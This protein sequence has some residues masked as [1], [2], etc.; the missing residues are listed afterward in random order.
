MSSPGSPLATTLCGILLRNPVIAASGTFG[1]G[2]DF[3]SWWTSTRW[4]AW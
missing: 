1:Y 2:V 4:A 3:E